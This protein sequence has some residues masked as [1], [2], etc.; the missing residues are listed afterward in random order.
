MLLHLHIFRCHQCYNSYK[1]KRSVIK[2]IRE[3]HR[4]S[5]HQE[6]KCE[7]C[8]KSFTTQDNLS[9][10]FLQIH[11]KIFRYTCSKCSEFKTHKRLALVQHLKEIHQVPE[12]E[13][14]SMIKSNYRVKNRA[15]GSWHQCSRCEF[16]TKHKCHL[17]LHMNRKHKIEAAVQSDPSCKLCKKEF[18]GQ[19][20]LNNHLCP[21][22]L[23]I[24]E[25]FSNATD[26]QCPGCNQTFDEMVC[27]VLT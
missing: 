25:R 14:E 10:H 16:T 8:D 26:L 5:K 4:K 12:S 11:S 20:G 6:F 1:D 22:R 18:L 3:F 23:K 15:I 21:V 13:M 24:N 19:Q 17:K 7:Q 9:S 27:I 2:H